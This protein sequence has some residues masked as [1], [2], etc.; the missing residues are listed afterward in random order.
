[1]KFFF[2]FLGLHPVT[3]EPSPAVTTASQNTVST[4]YETNADVTVTTPHRAGGRGDTKT[5]SKPTEINSSQGTPSTTAESSTSVAH[6]SAMVPQDKAVGT[7]SQ[8]A[9]GWWM[10][11]LSFGH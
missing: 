1:M 2:F 6:T 10:S 7:D 5:T 9:Q 11:Q 3:E 8:Q 4:A